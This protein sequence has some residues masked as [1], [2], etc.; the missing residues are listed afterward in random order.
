MNTQKN[1]N[2]PGQ[3]DYAVCVSAYSNGGNGKP[4][5]VVVISTDAGKKLMNFEISVRKYFNQAKL[6]SPVT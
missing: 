5:S 1:F 3:D 6:D 4:S 2:L